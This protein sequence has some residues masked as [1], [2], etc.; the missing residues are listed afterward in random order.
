MAAEAA[1]HG[2]NIKSKPAPGGRFSRW[3]GTTIKSIVP[4]AG[5]AGPPKG[6]SSMRSPVNP[7]DQIRVP[8]SPSKAAKSET[9]PQPEVEIE[10]ERQEIL[11]PCYYNNND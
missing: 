3:F 4:S 7:A 5:R 6:T 11:Y 10:G 1:T 9:Q 8:M 2:S